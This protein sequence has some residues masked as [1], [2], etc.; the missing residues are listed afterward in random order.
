MPLYE[1]RCPRCQHPFAHLWKT[2]PEAASNPPPVCPAC[3]HPHPRR[4][5][6]AAAVLGSL[7]G[8]TPG[9]KAQVKQT[10]ERMAS[11]TPKSQIE[12]WQAKRASRDKP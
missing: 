6:S 8:L 7:G 3:A 2:I 11:I 10:E 12:Q 5:V 1:Y 9:E 4:V